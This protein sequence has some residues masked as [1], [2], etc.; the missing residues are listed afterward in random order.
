M[1][2]VFV[3]ADLHFDHKNIISF[4]NRP[5]LDIEDMNVLLIKYWNQIV[6]PKDTVW[7]LGDFCISADP[8]RIK[9]FLNQLNGIKYLVKGNHD[10]LSNKQYLEAGFTWVYDYP[11]VLGDGF[12]ILSHEPIFLNDN[13]PFYNY[14]GHVHD[15]INFL[16]QTLRSR[17]VSVERTDYKPI[18]LKIK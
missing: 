5:F 16:T 3:I 6:S 14:F 18:F 17:C 13:T 1:N 7:V 4:C 15:N 2:K 8:K 12:V 11:V 10:I 9:H